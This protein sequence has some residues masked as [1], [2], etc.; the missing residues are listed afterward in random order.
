MREA[1]A[2]LDLPVRRARSRL[3]LRLILPVVGVS[4]ALLTIGAVAAWRIH[5]AERSTSQLLSMRVGSLRA[6]EELEILIREIRSQLNE[7]L[8]SGDEAHLNAAADLQPETERWLTE[9]FRLAAEGQ[10]RDLMEQVQQNYHRFTWEFAQLRRQPAGHRKNE[11]I[12][13]LTLRFLADRVLRPAHE[14]LDLTESEVAATSEK[15]EAEANRTAVALLV[16]GSTGA[17][18]GLLV[19]Y[20]IARG[21][22]R[23]LIQLSLPIHD[24]A[25]KLNLVVGPVTLSSG[26]NLEDMEEALRGIAARV[27]TVVERLQQSQRESLRSEQLAAVGQLAAGMAHELRN[28]LMAIKVLVQSAAS[29]EPEPLL[30]GRDLVILENEIDRLDQLLR[31][32]LEFARPSQLHKQRFDVRRTLEQTVALVAGQ[33]RQRGTV[34]HTDLP[35]SP[36]LVEADEAGLRQVFVNLLLNASDAI[37]VGGTIWIRAYQR[38]PPGPSWQADRTGEPAS[39]LVVEV[40]DSGCGLPSHLGERIFEPFVSTKETGMGLGLSTC[41]LVLESHGGQIHAGNR[42]EGGAVFA[43]VLP[44]RDA[45]DCASREAAREPCRPCS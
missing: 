3:I 32:L 1:Q 9:A 12:E 10:Q 18:S 15:N 19:G 20:A 7:F 35:A 38:K 45:T 11:A 4:L 24:A 42:P 44:M 21:V 37:G 29:N 6:A 41:K 14:Y 25:G 16:L 23:S 2:N 27:G 31:S 33:A 26:L 30:A 36:L 8:L 22:R 34:I 5:Q 40:A 13:N 43:V 28:P 39:Q 17:V